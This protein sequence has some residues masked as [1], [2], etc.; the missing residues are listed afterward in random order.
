MF[1]VMYLYY[2]LG[3]KR[4]DVTK[5]DKKINRSTFLLALDGDVDFQE[6]AL[7]KLMDL[8]MSDPE[9]GAACGRIH[10]VGTGMGVV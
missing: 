3:Y 4:A 6:D 10:P 1:Q 9:V 2:L 5:M 7:R 8:M